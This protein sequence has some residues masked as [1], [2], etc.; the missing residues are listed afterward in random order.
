MNDQ[1]VTFTAL[2]NLLY[3]AENIFLRSNSAFL[4]WNRGLLT[5]LVC[6]FSY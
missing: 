6:R 2:N 5:K 3:A 1:K 4:W